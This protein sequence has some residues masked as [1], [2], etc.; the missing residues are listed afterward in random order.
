VQVF[1]RGYYS[2]VVFNL[3]LPATDV[4][5][6]FPFHSNLVLSLSYS[7]SVRFTT[8][9]VLNCPISVWDVQTK[10]LFLSSLQ[11]SS[12]KC[13][14]SIGLMLFYSLQLSSTTSRWWHGIPTPFQFRTFQSE[15]QFASQVYH[16]FLVLNCPIS[17]WD[18]Q[19]KL[20][21]SSPHLP[22]FKSSCSVRA[23]NPLSLICSASLPRYPGSCMQ[24]YVVNLVCIASI[25][26]SSR[27]PWGKA[28]I[29]A[30]TSL[31]TGTRRK[32]FRL[33]WSLHHLLTRCL[34]E[35]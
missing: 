6:E 26:Y 2:S 10:L 16:S 22:N 1:H 7:S 14:C 3:P 20:L 8:L 21:L 12:I 17:V 18:V 11:P 29:V 32:I 23:A 15:L 25:D 4:D 28:Q 35:M 30:R 33:G 24:Q 13:S 34:D 5:T 9:L 27:A 19:T 31:N